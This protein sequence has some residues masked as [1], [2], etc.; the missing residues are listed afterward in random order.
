M[1]CHTCELVM[2]RDEGRAPLWDSIYRTDHWDIVHCNDTSLRGWLIL[3]ARRHI[4]ALDEMNTQEASELGLLIHGVSSA[5][6]SAVGCA[7]TYVV[8]FAEA[9][10]HQHVHFHLIPRMPDQPDDSRGVRVFRHL[11]VADSD[12]ISEQVMNDIGQRIRASLSS[13]FTLE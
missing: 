2:R 4:A 8:Q 3:V 12:R 10:G 13:S 9:A 6:K 1:E 11:G 5:L 7:K